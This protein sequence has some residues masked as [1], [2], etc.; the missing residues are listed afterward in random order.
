MFFSLC[1]SCF[2]QSSFLCF[3]LNFVLLFLQTLDIPK[4]VIAE[5][6]M[7]FVWFGCAWE[8]CFCSSLSSCWSLLQNNKKC[9]FKICILHLATFLSSLIYSE[10]SSVDSLGAPRNV[11]VRFPPCQK[12][13]VLSPLTS[14]SLSSVSSPGVKTNGKSRRPRLGPV[15]DWN[16]FVVHHQT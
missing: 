13:Y 7:L 9:L 8:L 15:L 5:Y 3:S 6:F 16:A 14:L 12:L 4:R 11:V 2:F 10:S 1:L